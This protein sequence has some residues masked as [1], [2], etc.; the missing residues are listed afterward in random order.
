MFLKKEKMRH[1]EA[2]QAEQ[3]QTNKKAAGEFNAEN[4]AV[5]YGPR[6]LFK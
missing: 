4:L 2:I 3:K 6:T 5:R 1:T